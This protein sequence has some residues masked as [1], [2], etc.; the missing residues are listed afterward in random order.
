M[1][2]GEQ[3]KELRYGIPMLEKDREK[4]SL[5]LSFMLIALSLFGYVCVWIFE[6]Y[7]W[8]FAFIVILIGALLNIKWIIDKKM[9]GRA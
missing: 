5:R 3:A 8:G 9:K 1:T 4:L 7:M 6:R 2:Y